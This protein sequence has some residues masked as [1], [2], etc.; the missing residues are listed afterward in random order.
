MIARPDISK[1]NVG[2][3]IADIERP[4]TQ[5]IKQAD[6]IMPKLNSRL[7]SRVDYDYYTINGIHRDVNLDISGRPLLTV[8]NARENFLPRIVYPD[9]HQVYRRNNR[10]KIDANIVIDQRNNVNTQININ[11]NEEVKKNNRQNNSDREGEWKNDLMMLSRMFANVQASKKAAN[12]IK[13]GET[14]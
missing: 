10:D 14:F 8:P 4:E 5:F 11:V 13:I 1:P 12:D 3:P 7:Q 9:R 2:A 6:I